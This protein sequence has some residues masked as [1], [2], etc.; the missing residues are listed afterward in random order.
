MRILH[1]LASPTFSGPAECVLQLA[2]AQRQLGHHVE[3]SVDRH[4]LQTAA[5]EPAVPRFEAQ[6]LLSGLPL[7][8]SVKSNPVG[9]VRDVLALRRAQFDVVHSHFSHDHHL[10][11]FSRV[12]TLIRSIHAP[13][14]LRW[15]TP[16]ATGWTVP[17]ESLTR[18]LLGHDVVV[19]P[20]LVDSAFTPNR[21]LTSSSR[22]GMVSTF[23]PS[24]RHAVGLTAF[25]L[26]QQR[27]PR[28]TLELIGDGAL[29]QEL[30]NLA[31]S[32]GNSVVF[33]GYLSGPEFVQALQSLDEV[34]VLGLGNDF[35]GR[36]AAQARA[37]GVRVVAVDEGAL[38]KWADVLVAPEPEAIAQVALTGQRR[39]AR[40]ESNDAVAQRVLEL[41][42]RALTASGAA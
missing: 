9:V 4:R 30:R 25:G 20:A 14:S 35:S 2:L 5:E 15:S 42:A 34:W 24:R 23:Q 39:D 6:G 27:S 18:A 21:S 11:R 31:K 1:L 40:I 29:A 38:D 28:A 37:C 22:I 17:S 10:A 8:L 41:Y 7:Q 16:S 32:F 13:R 19:L 33:R 3:V 12:P 26:V 36:A